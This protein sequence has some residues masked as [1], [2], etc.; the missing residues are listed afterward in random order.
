MIDTSVI[1]HVIDMK[2][3]SM[4]Q[5][6]IPA[7]IGLYRSTDYYDPEHSWHAAQIGLGSLQ[8]NT[9]LVKGADIPKTWR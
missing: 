3:R 4:L 2:N 5:A 9:D 8:Y 6:Y 1:E 7:G